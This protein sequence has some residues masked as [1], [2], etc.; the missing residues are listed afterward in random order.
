VLHGKPTTGAVLPSIRDLHAIASEDASRSVR[1]M[2]NRFRWVFLPLSIALLTVAIDQLIKRQ[3]AREIGPGSE[4]HTAWLIGDWLGLS[5]AQ[6]SGI[7][8]GLF[9]GRSNGLL[10]AGA[11]LVLI[12]I[13][14]FM[15]SRRGSPWVLVAGGMIG[16]GAVGNLLDRVRFGYVRDFF[17]VGPWPSFNVADSAITVGVLIALVGSL[18]EESSSAGDHADSLEVTP[19]NRRALLETNE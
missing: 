12:A 6:N 1:Q 10:I 15:R 14:A 3:V 11:L 13:G 8:F 17:A 9:Q 16:G 18:K 7:A 4:R 2:T 19:N 5:Y